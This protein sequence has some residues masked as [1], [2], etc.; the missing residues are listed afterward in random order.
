MADVGLF[1][2]LVWLSTV[3]SGYDCDE[4]Y[5]M[6]IVFGLPIMVNLYFVALNKQGGDSWIGLFFK[7]KALEERKKIDD[8]K[9]PKNSQK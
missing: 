9:N 1:G 4:A 3:C 5:M 6:F 2:W 7:R 8:L